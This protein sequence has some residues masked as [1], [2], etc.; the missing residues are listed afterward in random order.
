MEDPR[1]RRKGPSPS[2]K[3]VKFEPS[4]S[5]P[6]G[7]QVREEMGSQVRR[8]LPFQVCKQGSVR[9][10]LLVRAWACQ[11]FWGK[12]AASPRVAAPKGA[13]PW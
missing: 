12:A 9:P 8:N 1:A 6:V 7:G 11:G 5:A 10:L 3:F 2:V 13:V 4:P